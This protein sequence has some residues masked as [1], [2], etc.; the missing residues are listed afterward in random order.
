MAIPD[1]CRQHVQSIV[2]RA[3]SQHREKITDLH[4]RFKEYHN[5]KMTDLHARASDKLKAAKS[6]IE[7]L[8]GVLSTGSST[9]ERHS[10]VVH[11]ELEN[12]RDAWRTRRA[13][14]GNV[15][16]AVGRLMRL[17]QSLTTG[18]DPEGKYAG[19]EPTL[20]RFQKLQSSKLGKARISSF[21]KLG[22]L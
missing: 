13:N 10:A 7:G 20:D 9:S 8:K 4:Q 16:T 18:R 11:N 6:R 22:I 17:H 3:Q 2:D 1:I 12:L 19:A 14:P 5:Q 21:R 15:T